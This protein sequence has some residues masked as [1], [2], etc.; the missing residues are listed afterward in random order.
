MKT[1]TQKYKD[2][3][4]RLEERIGLLES[5]VALAH[6]FKMFA[7]AESRRLRKK[8][9]ALGDPDLALSEIELEQRR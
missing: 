5:E 1:T 6:N 4:A 8:L 2:R 7:F 3:I 9:A